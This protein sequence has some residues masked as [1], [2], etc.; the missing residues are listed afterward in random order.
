VGF[1]LASEA[2]AMLELLDVGGRRVHV[3]DLDGLGPGRHVIELDTTHPLGSG[4]YFLR[5]TQDGR[6]ATRRVAVVQ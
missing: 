6:T 1:S 2:R 3:Q 4:V 5:L